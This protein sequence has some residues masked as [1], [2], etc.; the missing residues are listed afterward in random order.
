[1]PPPPLAPADLVGRVLRRRGAALATVSI[2]GVPW[3]LQL[4]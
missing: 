2:G 4:L 3:L 1:M